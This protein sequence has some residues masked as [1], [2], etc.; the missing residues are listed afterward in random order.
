MLAGWAYVRGAWALRWHTR[1]PILLFAELT[2][3]LGGCIG[4]VAEHE[5]VIALVL[6]VHIDGVLAQVGIALLA[7]AHTDFSQRLTAVV[8]REAILEWMDGDAPTRTAPTLQ[9]QPTGHRP[10]HAPS[11]AWRLL[12]RGSA[13]RGLG[14]LAVGS[15]VVEEVMFRGVLLHALV[16]C[17]KLGPVTHAARV[18]LPQ[19][20]LC[21]PGPFPRYTGLEGDH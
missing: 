18:S 7:R 20:L 3:F 2:V 8:C 17:A 9:P 11:S 6:I 16:T 19:P 1:R 15:S 12:L 4:Q 13:L 14:T 5:C 21:A 10:R